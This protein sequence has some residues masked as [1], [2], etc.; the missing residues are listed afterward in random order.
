MKHCKKVVD[1]PLARQDCLVDDH[2]ATSRPP[3]AG[4]PTVPA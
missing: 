3:A 2:A 1:G 4:V